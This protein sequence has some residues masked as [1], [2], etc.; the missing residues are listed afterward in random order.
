MFYR[1]NCVINLC[2]DKKEVLSEAYRVLKSGG[3]LY[4]SDVYADRQLS[5]EGRSHEVLWGKIL[6]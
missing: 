6:R 1:S 3:E 4:F 2:K 5:E